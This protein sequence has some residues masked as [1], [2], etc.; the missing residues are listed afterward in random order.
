MVPLDTYTGNVVDIN[1]NPIPDVTVMALGVKDIDDKIYSTLTDEAGD[2][3][4][5]IPRNLIDNAFYDFMAT[6][7]NYITNNFILLKK[8]EFIT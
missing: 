7:S 1:G 6:K 8:I 2:F 5:S 4:I 3:L